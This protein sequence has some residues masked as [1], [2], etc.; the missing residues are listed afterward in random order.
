M[1]EVKAVKRAGFERKSAEESRNLKLC[2]AC[3]IGGHFTQ[4]LELKDVYEKYEHFFVTNPGKQTISILKNKKK[5]FMP[6]RKGKKM[7]F[8]KQFLLSLKILLIE[9]PDVIITT[10]SGDMFWICVLAKLFRKRVIYIESFAR[11]TSPSKFGKVAYKFAD[12]F[13]Y[14]WRNLKRFYPHGI[15]GGV[16]FNIPDAN[17]EDDCDTAYSYF[18]T[19]GTLP[20]DFSRL[21]SKVDELI[22]RGVINGRVF[23]QIGYSRYIPKNYEYTDF[24][25]LDKFEDVIKKSEMVI[26]HG[27]VGSIMSALK[28]DKRTI[29]VPRY[30]KFREIAD[31]HQLDITR[32]LEREGKIVAVYDIDDLEEAIRKAKALKVRMKSRDTR[33]KRIIIDWLERET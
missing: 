7:N 8:L 26:T 6:Q 14:Q 20:N 2:L 13:I 32:E 4:M 11:V 9:K 16:I 25:D 33:I 23:A 3:S 28:N 17:K 21:L 1:E 24:L 31:D 22:E 30:R 12:L 18:I 19:V 5:Y 29:V 10:G 15:Y 27:G